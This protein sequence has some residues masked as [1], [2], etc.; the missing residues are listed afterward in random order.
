[1]RLIQIACFYSINSPE[2]KDVQFTV[3]HD[4]TSKYSNG[5]NWNRR[6]FGIVFLRFKN[7][8]SINNWFSTDRL[9]VLMTY[10]FSLAYFWEKE[11]WKIQFFRFFCW[12]RHSHTFYFEVSYCLY[13]SEWWCIKNEAVPLTHRKLDWLSAQRSAQLVDCTLPFRPH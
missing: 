4:K 7:S 5:R 12:H 3:I 2:L 11:I 8:Q 10:L 6:V 9:I 1:M 13:F